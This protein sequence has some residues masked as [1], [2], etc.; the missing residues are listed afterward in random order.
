MPVNNSSVKIILIFAYHIP[1]VIFMRKL[2]FLLFIF[3]LGSVNAQNT[4]LQKA[5][6]GG[7]G[8]D[9]A[10]GFAIGNTGYILSG[11]DTGGYFTDMWAWNSGTNVWNEVAPFP[12]QKRFGIRSVSFSGYGYV[13]GGEEPAKCYGPIKRHGGV[14]A[15]TFFADIW[16]YNPDSNSW[17]ELNPFPG[18]SRNFAVA[19]ADP[20]DSTIYYGTGNDN[21]S[22]YLSDWWAFYIPGNTWTRLADFP[23]GQRANAIGFFANGNIYAGTGNDNDPANYATSD[24]WQ[25]TPSS[26]S[27]KQVADVPGIPLRCA[28]AF[29]I[30]NYGYVCLG[31]G[32]TTYTT[33]GWKY[34]AASNAWDSIANY[35]GGFMADAVAFTI[36]SNGYVGTGSHNG[37]E[38]SQFWE[39]S[40]VSTAPNNT[41][42]INLYP[43]PAK[44]TMYFNY[45][46]ITQLPATLKLIDALGN[47]MNTYIINN[48]YG[49]VILDVATF[50]SGTYFYRVYGSGKV[51]NSGKFVIA[52]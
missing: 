3:V 2:L 50:N 43:N 38:Y 32:D 30:N 7:G 46:G 39:Y 31:I 20:D 1:H 44:S 51:L 42:F 17:L 9:D 10:S 24:F 21:D 29:S 19:M 52:R 13:L 22:A 34:N 33:G 28:S 18:H 23:G 8:R 36:G 40:T 5:D 41:S 15:G 6:F 35:G 12:A 11:T 37:N 14:C 27:W 45:S 25:Y 48:N 47:I 16:R 26:N 49:Q 4:W